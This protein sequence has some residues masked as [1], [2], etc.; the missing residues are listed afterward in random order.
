MKKH[1]RKFWFLFGV[2]MLLIGVT[3]QGQ[4]IWSNGP[5]MSTA[6]RNIRPPG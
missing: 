5:A 4:L 2:A 6:H 3:A 1:L